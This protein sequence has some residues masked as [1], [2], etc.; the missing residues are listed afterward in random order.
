MT[1]ESRFVA[2]MNKILKDVRLYPKGRMLAALLKAVVSPSTSDANRLL[3]RAVLIAQFVRNGSID[4]SDDSLLALAEK[5][6]RT[7]LEED[8]ASLTKNW[9]KEALSGGVN[10]DAGSVQS[11]AE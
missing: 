5:A 3:F 1:S 9:L 2:D 11:S 6:P 10:A 4:I 8:T 7:K